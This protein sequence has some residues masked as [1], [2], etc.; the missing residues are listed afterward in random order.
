MSVGWARYAQSL[1]QKPVKG[2][3]TGPV[4]I[5]AG[6]SSATDQPLADT[7]NQ[8]ALAL[9]D[10]I[11]ELEAAGHPDHPSGRTGAAG[12]AAAAARRPPG[13]P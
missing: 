13:V 12:A 5:L 6:P 8:V 3:L 2:M 1:T 10:E 11:S 9:R 4:T 7:A